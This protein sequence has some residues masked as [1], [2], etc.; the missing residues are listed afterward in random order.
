MWVLGARMIRIRLLATKLLLPENMRPRLLLVMMSFVAMAW[1]VRAASGD[2]ARK[3][4]EKVSVL[5]EQ[6]CLDCHSGAEPEGQ[7]NLEGFASSLVRHGQRDWE[8]DHW[9]K[10]HRRLMTRQMP[11]SGSDRPTDEQYEQSIDTIAH[12][13]QQHADQ[14]PRPGT[15]ASMRRM[16]RFEYR[17]AVRDLLQLDIDVNELLPADSESH[18]FD[19]VTTGELSPTLLSRYLSAAEQISRTAVGRKV[20]FVEGRTVRLP[21]DRTQDR[22]VDGLPLGTRG[23]TIVDHHFPQDG[24][25][26]V[27][28]RLT[29][30]R[31][32]KVEGVRGTHDLDILLDGKRIDRLTTNR[33]KNGDYSNVDSDLNT[34][35]TVTAGR[36][37]LGVTFPQQYRSLLEIKRQPFDASFNRHRHPRQEPAVFEVSIVGPFQSSGAKNT[38]SRDAIFISYP[39]SQEDELACG[40]EIIRNLVRKAY[41]RPPTESDLAVPL[42]FFQQELEASGFDA[43]IEVAIASILVNPNFLFRV[44]TVPKEIQPGQAYAISDIE[45]ASRLSFFLWSSIPDDQL[46]ALAERGE[47]HDPAVLESQVE[48]M[49]ADPRAESLATN[50]ASQWLHLRNL[51]SIQPDLR[52]FPDWDDNLRQAFRKETEMLFYDAVKHD[53]SVLT[54]IDSPYTF[55]NERL[56]VHYGIEHVYGSHFRRVELD[57]QARRGGL[58]RQGSVLTVTSYATRTSPTIRGDWILSNLIGTPPPP[59]PPNVPALEEKDVAAA[60]LSVRDRLSLHRA[61]PTCATCHDLIDPLGF[62]LENFDAV[63]RW[64][65]FEFGQ[66]VDVSGQLPDGSD[67]SGVDALE[68]SFLERPEIFATTLVEKL[69]TYGLGRGIES[70]DGPA[71]R[72]VISAA[73]REDYRFSALIKGIVLS[74][75]FLM[76]TAP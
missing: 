55:L 51:E 63:G 61:N 62:T 68:K 14:F 4:S 1:N 27:Q 5:I 74:P 69:M 7:F 20:D 40:E 67:L 39:T 71:I 70:H 75:P 33:P 35:F 57:P 42:S 11:P 2:E 56:A 46:L 18:G 25:Y 19:N 52:L 21:A 45:L 72:R 59:P 58:L 22:H 32:E 36:H 17:Q 37:Q 13:L 41:R 29:R 15:T 54:L 34:R 65:A 23:G 60:N 43:G 6:Y 30:D 28:V 12:R 76:R 44:E 16:T 31:D 9:E 53:R 3:S 50:F 49:L 10:V 66:P 8:A 47:L 26:E 38:L 24:Q 73:E 48:R 64:R